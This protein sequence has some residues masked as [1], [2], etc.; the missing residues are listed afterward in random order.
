MRAAEA[1]ACLPQGYSEAKWARCA[2]RQPARA[3]LE[4]SATG[5]E[6]AGVGGSGVTWENSAFLC[7]VT[8]PSRSPGS[9]SSR[10]SRGPSRIRGELYE[11]VDGASRALPQSKSPPSKRT[12][13]IPERESPFFYRDRI[14]S[15][16]ATQC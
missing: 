9:P 3:S 13:C 12:R 5:G 8:G 6:W 4:C 15:R 2:P 16:A 7:S 10:A 11:H 1:L 14:V